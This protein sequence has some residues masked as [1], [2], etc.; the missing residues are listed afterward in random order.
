LVLLGKNFKE[1]AI[2][3]WQ[4]LASQMAMSNLG[5]RI[6]FVTEIYGSATDDLGAIYSGALC[7]VQPSLY[8]GFGLPVL[9]AMQTQTP[10]VCTHNSSLIEVG[11]GHVVYVDTQAQSIA[12]GIKQIISWSSEQRSEVIEQAK[13]WALSFSWSK[14]AQETAAV[15]QSLL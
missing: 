11:N 5:D 12:E 8:E 3:E 13:Q 10:V 7:Y 2:P 9:E 1:Q 14:T 4:W 6:H 15:Y